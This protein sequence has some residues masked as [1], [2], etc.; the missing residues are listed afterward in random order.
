MGLLNANNLNNRLSNSIS[1]VLFLGI[2]IITLLSFVS[3][4]WK[5]LVLELLSH[6]KIQYLILN[7]I[8][9]C[10]LLLTRRKKLIF[11]SL[12]CLSFV[13]SE[14]IPWYIPPPRLENY[15]TKLRILSLNVNT[16]NQSYSQV[17]SMVRREQPDVAVFMEINEAWVKQLNSLKNILP[18]TVANANPYNLGIAVYSKI[19]LENSAIAFFG[20]TNNPSITGRLTFN[21][22]AISLVAIHPPPPIKPTLFQAR[23]QQLEEVS[24][25]IRS[26]SSFVIIVGDFNITMWSP[27]YKRFVINTGLKNARKGFG[28]LPTWPLKTTYPPYSRIPSLLSWLLSI[29]IDHCLISPQIKVVKIR[30]GSDLGS[31]HR[32]LITDLVVFTPSLSVTA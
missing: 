18:N 24:Q 28:I 8:L 5:N 2:I 12:L 13:S 19:P 11:I 3:S 32:S 27:Y 6:F 7:I 31:D 22:K 15:S 9:F 23:N 21:G 20:K 4:F 26:L 14:I 16:Q 29:P 17:L 10:G 1:Y 25:Y 30:T